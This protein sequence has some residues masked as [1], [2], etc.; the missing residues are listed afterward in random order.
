M[1]NATLTPQ[2]PPPVPAQ[3]EHSSARFFTPRLARVL[4][5]CSLLASAPSHGATRY[6][7]TELSYIH[8]DNLAHAARASDALADDVVLARATANWLLPLAPN[9]GLLASLTGEYHGYAHWQALSRTVLAG[10]LVYR[11]KPSA[12]FNAPWLEASVSGGL[13][14]FQDSAMRD[15]GRLAFEAAT[16]SALTDRFALRLAYRFALDRSWRDTVFDGE[17]HRVYGSVDW[18]IE[19]T[20]FYTTLAW[21]RGDIVAS[22][23]ENPGLDRVARAHARDSALADSP[24]A[25]I[26]YRFE[27]DT[28]SA[29]LGVNVALAAGLAL[30]VSALYFDADGETK[31]HYRGLRVTAGVLYRF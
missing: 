17:T 13:R 8:E 27:A 10:Q 2:S 18:H 22:V 3:I 12:A 21:Q 15:G 9:G 6:F 20:T 24:N 5:G 16:G 26:A 7:D 28:L 14:Q 31:A 25:R 4:M 1:L 23:T 29:A 19:R 30:D 11:H